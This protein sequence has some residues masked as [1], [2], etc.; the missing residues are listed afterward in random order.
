MS[1]PE[2][3]REHDR[4]RT[5]KGARI[6]FNNGNSTL[7]VMVRD[8]SEGGAKLKLG[9]ATCFVPDVFDLVVTN[10]NTGATTKHRCEKRWHRGDLIG[11]RFLETPNSRAPAAMTAANLRQSPTRP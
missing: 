10:A 11:A 5:L 4:Y 9:S 1:E 6:I 8:M 2:S 3:P 7:N